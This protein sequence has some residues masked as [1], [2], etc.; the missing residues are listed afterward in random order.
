MAGLEGEGPRGEPT[1]PSEVRSKQ[2]QHM[3]E[4]EL[5]QHIKELQ[6]RFAKSHL[7]EI[8][9]VSE[10]NPNLFASRVLGGL[11]AVVELGDRYRRTKNKLYDELRPQMKARIE[12][13]RRTRNPDDLA[14]SADEKSKSNLMS[15]YGNQLEG[16]EDALTL[17][18]NYIRLGKDP[19]FDPDYDGIVPKS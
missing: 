16:L 8:R 15:Q 18:S 2:L 11:R 13:Y 12:T 19:H 4:S 6:A 9:A 17:I 7:E 14:E 1:P 3:S 10:Q 5:M